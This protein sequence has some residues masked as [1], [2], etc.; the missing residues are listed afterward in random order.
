[1]I[2][3]YSEKVTKLMFFLGDKG[4]KKRFF[5]KSARGLYIFISFV[6]ILTNAQSVLALSQSTNYNLRGGQVNLFAGKVSSV[7]YG[8]ETG[9]Q[10]IAGKVLGSSYNVQQGSAFSGRTPEPASG[11]G[12]GG[13]G[14]GGFPPTPPPPPAPPEPA[15]LP[16]IIDLTISDI[17]ANQARIVFNTNKSTISYINYGKGG[18]LNLVTEEE[19]SFAIAHEFVL[20][21]LIPNSAY[22]FTVHLQDLAA[23]TVETALYSFNTLPIFKA[24]PNASNFVAEAKAVS[25]DLSWVNPLIA[26]LAGV[27][28][29]RS[30]ADY[31]LGLSDG[32][33]VFDGFAN[34]Y[35]DFDV[36]PNQRYYYTLFAYDTSLNYSSGAIASAIIIPVPEEPLP[37]PIPEEPVPEPI[38]PE[39]PE[40]VPPS[41]P[42]E[43]P[44]IPAEP[45]ELPVELTPTEE[46]GIIGGGGVG[47]ITDLLG[48]GIVSFISLVK[49]G[50]S[51]GYEKLTKIFGDLSDESIKQI[52]QI[53]SGLVDGAGKLQQ[54]IY[55]A[56]TPEEK[57]QIEEI[58]AQPLPPVFVP[59]SIIQITP[60]DLKAEGFDVNWHIFADSDSILSIPASVFIKPVK[61]IIATMRTE[62]Y[63]LEYNEKTE[64][65]E[66]IVRA[67][68]KKGTYQIIIQIIYT[69]NSYEEISGAVLVDPY[70][71]VYI[72]EYKDWS[73]T[74]PWQVF[75]SEEVRVK[76]AIVTLYT[77]NKSG[78]WVVWP[79]NLYR[80][81]NPQTTNGNGEYVF[82][83]PPGKYYLTAYADGF[84]GF[85]SSRID[86]S[87]DIV[88]LNIPL[89]PSLREVIEPDAPILENVLNV[90]RVLGERTAQQISKIK[91]ITDQPEVEDAT[92]KIVAPAAVGT[93][94]VVLAPSFAGIFFPLLKFL[95]LQPMLLF[96]LRKRKK[97]GTVYN[98]LNK[99]PVDLAII[100]L[101][102]LETNK[103]VQSKVTDTEG[104][105]GFFV[106]KPGKYKIQAIKNNF[107]FPSKFLAQ[108]DVDGRM[109]DIYHG[110]SVIVDEENVNIAL[111]V[112]LDPIDQDK[113]PRRIILE[114]KLRILQ[115]VVAMSGIFTTTAS[116]IVV[117]AWYIWLF[118]ALH[119][120]SYVLFLKFIVPKK[121][122]GWGMVYD[123]ADK[124]PIKKALVRLFSK[125][126]NKLIDFN[127]TDQKGRYAMLVGPSDYYVT[128]EKE[129]YASHKMDDLNLEKSRE[130]KILIK[131]DVGMS[132][133]DPLAGKGN[134]PAQQ[135]SVVVPEKSGIRQDSTAIP[136]PTEP[137]EIWEVPK[138]V[139][140]NIGQDVGIIEAGKGIDSDGKNE[141]KFDDDNG[142][143][144][145]ESGRVRW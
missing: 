16:K 85:K 48:D 34:S 30:T 131:D 107:V 134:Y 102:D 27:K 21:N 133:A 39:E 80:Q 82:V 15:D 55:Q 51:K 61:A 24:V 5:K 9:G 104:N 86:I 81:Y 75:Q 62:A 76:G 144:E 59:E 77:L 38:P 7:S 12:A 123:A 10:P 110:E 98:S 140:D 103:V 33:L 143:A 89:T 128:F 44:I 93:S 90:T 49:Q 138:K 99:L 68:E 87:K 111:N 64:N 63:I 115:H 60:I 88:N 109:V 130:A 1:M 79:A 37:E 67:P 120:S 42:G 50:V 91:D 92:K 23:N 36:V 119:I 78:V 2:L 125:K 41:P 8:L 4:F 43:E 135:S 97:Y 65:Y 53:S 54:D 126:Y 127:V 3:L 137:G 121:T 96:G 69:D 74:K 19:S 52:N 141:D 101:I 105:Y 72:K 70:G 45:P 113:T 40:P 106:I 129:G 116:L 132:K 71:Y 108:E 73:W 25:I 58:I 35:S 22:N 122:K 56:L 32:E 31:P 11:G 118:L 18:A 136:T 124:S 112:P 28:I 117:N 94:F 83:A 26:D 84:E 14:G 6:L 100:R 114:K 47:Q 20:Y 29:I 57:K 139:D 13:A 46:T 66:A 95:F 145:T 17:D 142:R